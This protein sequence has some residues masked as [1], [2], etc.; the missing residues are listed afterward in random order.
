MS[1]VIQFIQHPLTQ[2]KDG[3]DKEAKMHVS[4]ESAIVR[5]DELEDGRNYKRKKKYIAEWKQSS[6]YQFVGKENYRSHK[7]YVEGQTFS[8]N[9]CA[10]VHFENQV[11]LNSTFSTTLQV[12][13]DDEEK[14]QLITIFVVVS[15]EICP[16]M[17]TSQ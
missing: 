7:T 17:K 8:W 15:S 9:S 4:I 14:Q 10:V 5:L 1:T 3:E 13:Y 2:I 11:S 12:V 16:Q 6:F